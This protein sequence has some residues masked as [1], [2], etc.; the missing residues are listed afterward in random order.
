MP[1]SFSFDPEQH[2]CYNTQTEEWIPTSTQVLELAGIGPSFKTMVDR[3][4]IKQD[5]LDRRCWIGRE[6]HYLT[7]ILDQDGEVPETWLHPDTEGY[8]RS[9]EGFKQQT[10]FIPTA[11]SVRRC[12]LIGGMPLSGETDCEGTFPGPRHTRIPAIVDKKT[13]A[14]AS[15]S[16][17]FQLA[18]YEQLK[19]Q[20]TKIGRLLRVVAHL[21]KDGAPG[22][23]LTYGDVS[24]VDGVNYADGFLAALHCVHIG[25]RRGYISER[26]VLE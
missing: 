3:G 6:V 5:T 23:A 25:I 2:V 26:D 16:W 14:S 1:I 9:W 10:G 24:P 18:S 15:D 20:S 22:R 17:G 7:D 13:G 12:E 19:F 8:V 21:N 4:I 11:W